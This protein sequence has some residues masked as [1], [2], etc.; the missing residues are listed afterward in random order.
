[1][2][3]ITEKT[4]YVTE[5]GKEYNTREAAER[6][7][8]VEEL[9]KKIEDVTDYRWD[10]E[11]LVDILSNKEIL[12]LLIPATG[13]FRKLEWREIKGEIAFADE[14]VFLI[15]SFDENEER[16]HSPILRDDQVVELVFRKYVNNYLDTMPASK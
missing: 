8:S 6:M 12:R 1:M 13:K 10:A 5:A 7:Q 9:S 3:E 15:I 11:E 4:V 14:K 2:G 16:F